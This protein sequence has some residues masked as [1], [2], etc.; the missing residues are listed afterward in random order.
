MA[1]RKAGRPSHHPRKALLG[2]GYV[3]NLWNR[4]GNTHSAEQALPFY[5]QTRRALAGR[6]NID[7][8]LGESGFAED[9]ML[10]HLEQEPQRYILAVRLTPYVLAGI[11]AIGIWRQI[12]DGLEIGE[13]TLALSTWIRPRR[14]VV[15]RQH[16]H[17]RP[18]APGK[19]PLLFADLEEHREW[20]YSVMVTND[21]VLAAVDIWRTYRPRANIENG[22]K[23]LTYDYGWDEF[24]VHS[25]GGTEAVMLLVGM[26]CYNLVHYLNRCVLHTADTV[27]AR[28]KTLRPRLLAIP[29]LYGSG[30]R[31]PT[32]RLGI[33]DRSLRGKF[34]YW[35]AQISQLTVRLVNCNAVALPR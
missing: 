11:Q 24:N 15:V 14:F 17:K 9:A 13:M 31:R 6:V 7:W 10:T 35:L 8:V 18:H 21:T 33:Q 29:A 4:S 27:L 19:Q 5:D 16:I 20:R 23:E 12:E 2:C 22:I 30:G 1:S 25:F 3:V 28:L 32:L 34:C 26:V